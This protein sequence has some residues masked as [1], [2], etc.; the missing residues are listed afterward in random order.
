[1]NVDPRYHTRLLELR[2][3]KDFAAICQFL[4]MF[5]PAFA[6]EDFETEDLEQALVDPNSMAFLV[7]LQARML[8]ALTQDR[9]ISFDNWI[10]Y[11][12]R[13]FEKREDEMNPWLE[14]D[15][16]NYESFSLATKLMILMNLCEWQ[17]DDPERFRANFKETED[18]AVEWRV[19]PI[20]SDANERTYW[21]FDDNRLY[22]ENPPT[23]KSIKKTKQAPAPPTPKSV[24]PLRR[25]TR[26][27]TRGHKSEPSPEPEPSPEFETPPITPGVEWEP[28]CIT[29]QEWEEFANVFQRSKHADEK[30]LH[31]IVNND[32]LPKVLGDF[33]EKEKEREKLEAIANRKRSSRIVLREFEIQEKARLEA[34]RQQELQAVAEQRRQEL[35]ERRAEKARLHMHT[36][37]IWSIK[38]KALFRCKER[39][40]QQQIREKR[41][42]EREERLKAREQAVWEREEKKK[43][44]LQVIAKQREDRKKRRLA[45][46]IKDD[47]SEDEAVK[48]E[49]EE[50]DWLFD[51]VC[52]VHGSN[53]DDGEL[54]VACGKCNVWQHVACL[55]Q[56]DAAQG[57]SV[58]DWENVDFTCPR[59][60]L[61]EQKKVARKEKKEQKMR[62]EAMAGNIE[63]GAAKETKKAAK[64]RPSMSHQQLNSQTTAHT[65]GHY[66]HVLTH[67]NT[68]PMSLPSQHSAA[69]SGQQYQPQPQSFHGTVP[70]H[71]GAGVLHAPPTYYHGHSGQTLTSHS[72]PSPTHPYPQPHS[73]HQHQH[74]HR[75]HQQQQQQQQLSYLGPSHQHQQPLQQTPSQAQYGSQHIP[76]PYSS[77][78]VPSTQNLGQMHASLNRHSTSQPQQYAGY[79]TTPFAQPNSNTN[80]NMTNGSTSYPQHFKGEAPVYGQPLAPSA[81]GGH[82]ATGL[83]QKRVN[84]MED[85]MDGASLSTRAQENLQGTNIMLEGVIRA[86]ANKFDIETNPNGMVNLGVAENQLMTEEL[87]AI[88]ST[89]DTADPKLFGYG[90]SPSGSKQL[91]ELFADNIFNRYFNPQDRVQAEDIVLAA[92]CSAIVDMFTFCVCDPS[93]GIMITTPFYGGFITDIAVKSKAK[94]VPV[95][96]ENMSPFDMDHIQLMQDAFEKAKSEGTT[97]RA[98]VLSNPHNPLGRNH[99]PELLIEFLKFANK[100]KIHVLYDEIYALSVFDHVLTGRAKE[101]QPDSPPFI[102]VLSIPNLEQ[103]CDLELIHVA[104]GMSKDFCLNGFRCGVLLSP[105][106]K[107]LVKAMR[108]ISVFTWMS[109]TTEAMIIKLLS[110]SKTIDT[111][112]KTNQQRL[113]ESY[114]YTVDLLREHNIPYVPAQAGH[115]LW[116]DL[117]PYIPSSLVS[118]ASAGDRAAEYLLWRAML[119]EGVY[120][121][122]GEAFSESKVGFFR[123]SFS[124][125]IPQ[126]KIGMERMIKACQKTVSFS[127]V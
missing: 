66:Q 61:K 12:Q 26:R 37:K 10:K 59:C 63:A 54:M 57:R 53:L 8:R 52:G 115:F 75:H 11:A 86:N 102:S 44:Q 123:L 92:G 112:T 95:N 32:I 33:K 27:S 24:P 120:V 87:R 82:G 94:V 103:Y 2:S 119:D 41:L 5:H 91:R 101:E 13:E 35:R 90:E 36:M 105:W 76:P 22:R 65:N 31:S 43:K 19:D 79:A 23:K 29:Q 42:K 113:A 50:E 7:D 1:M 98:L 15:A 121:N 117:R 125:P 89:V 74:Q 85:G 96:L 114:T 80:F 62:M 106:N 71:Q 122:L 45:G 4:H 18:I 9:R 34:I 83:V 51:C 70:Y 99:S 28:V 100:N 30:A 73:Q 104:Y 68:S 17:L 49:E 46:G 97:I 108:S 110:D 25:G 64:K 39:Q 107:E 60:I 55:R 38:D 14:E 67:S 78:Y 20:G 81:Y 88:M 109:S 69:Y 48:Q 6:L 77:S 72:Y 127:P 16:P 40:A 124:V 118:A 93:D 111:F 126:L 21:L 58:T 3:M 116:I 47:H 56:E 84:P